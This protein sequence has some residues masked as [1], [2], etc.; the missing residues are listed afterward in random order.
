[1]CYSYEYDN[2]LLVTGAM[3]MM[4]QLLYLVP[5]SMGSSKG[6]SIPT[7]GSSVQVLVAV[8]VGRSGPQVRWESSGEIKDG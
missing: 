7:L 8:I 2:S 4:V 3:I 5:G 6:R 1:L